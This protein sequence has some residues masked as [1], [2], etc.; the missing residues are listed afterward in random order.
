MYVTRD[1]CTCY[2]AFVNKR[3]FSAE[4]PR[5]TCKIPQALAPITQLPW[6]FPE[7]SNASTR[8][9]RDRDRYPGPAA[10]PWPHDRAS[11]DASDGD[12]GQCP[13]KYPR[14]SG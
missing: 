5:N 9:A 12:C 13:S 11:H 8:G 6:G 10:G 1:T 4:R 2:M 14:P 7:N 3:C